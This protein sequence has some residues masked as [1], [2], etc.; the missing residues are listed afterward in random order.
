MKLG[1]D[2][3][4][5]RI[6]YKVPVNYPATIYSKVVGPVKFLKDKGK[7][8]YLGVIETLAKQ[9]VSP[10]RYKIS[11]PDGFQTNPKLVKFAYK[12]EPKVTMFA[13]LQKSKQFVPAPSHYSPV[14]A[15]KILG[16]YTV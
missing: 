6:Q 8:S 11:D 4:F 5:N 3:E 15:R 1:E 9:R 7:M 12:K 2:S 16:N 14:R 13:E 10:D